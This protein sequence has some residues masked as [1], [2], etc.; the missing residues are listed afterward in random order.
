MNEVTGL[1]TIAEQSPNQRL[2]QPVPPQQVTHETRDKH[3]FLLIF[4]LML[5]FFLVTFGLATFFFRP[6]LVLGRSLY[7]TL[8]Q[9][10]KT[11]EVSMM[12]F[13]NEINRLDIKSQTDSNGNSLKEYSVVKG[14]GF[15][16]SETVI[17][18]FLET[19]TDSY[20]NIYHSGKDEFL[21]KLDEVFPYVEQ[22]YSVV[23][24][25]S[26][27][28]GNTWLKIEYEPED[29]AGSIAQSALE[30][31]NLNL[32]Q[33]YMLTSIIGIDSFSFNREDKTYEYSI[34]LR[35]EF[36]DLVRESL[37]S[38]EYIDLATK[39]DLGRLAAIFEN[40]SGWNE[41]VTALKINKGDGYIKS[42]SVELPILYD[43]GNEK[44]TLD[45]AF[46]GEVT[47]LD[48]F[49]DSFVSHTNKV[50][51]NGVSHVADVT[52]NVD[53][54]Q[55]ISVPKKI[56]DFDAL[57]EET[58]GEIIIL[59][60]MLMFD[61]DM[62]EGTPPVV[63]SD[64]YNLKSYE[65]KEF[66]QNEDYNSMITSASELLALAETDEEE[67]IANYWM[68][69][70]YYKLDSLDKAE[71]YL[72]TAVSLDDTYHAPYVTLAAIAYARNEV[73]KGLD[74]SLKCAELDPNYGWCY[75]NIG[76]GYSKQGDLAQGIE[77]VERA[78]SLDPTNTKFKNNLRL[79][80]SQL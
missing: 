77:N 4:G 10:V 69:L 22:P 21:Q 15:V 58:K 26:M 54:E 33:Q 32:F 18:K 68:G 41:A 8:S 47:M 6:R 12:N 65:T 30:D 53:P 50:N 36:M 19:P 13:T 49:M 34:H 51:E 46:M 35:E 56:V 16:G 70:G 17:I 5:S 27:L 14:E 40:T 11:V 80:Q 76:I 60:G 48:F 37:L 64:Q 71:G 23:L 29:I 38:E 66:Y 3:I 39:E 1:N 79:M 74:Y 9:E 20:S 67:A 42:V 52:I 72:L 45:K 7:K 24:I 63:V 73:Q 61:V 28:N 62:P 43:D 55:T 57:S 25:K 31:D 75:N 44:T 78:I 59:L 2:S